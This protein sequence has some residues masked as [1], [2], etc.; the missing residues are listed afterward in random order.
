MSAH[1]ASRQQLGGDAV[2]LAV[3]VG[4]DLPVLGVDP[5]AAGGEGGVFDQLDV[6]E[7][8][9]L[10]LQLREGVVERLPLRGMNGDA[11]VG[12]VTTSFIASA[13]LAVSTCGI[14][15]PLALGDATGDGDR[16]LDDFRQRRGFQL[17]CGS[18][19]SCQ[20]RRSGRPTAC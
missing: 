15:Q 19:R 13:R 17:A 7:A 5:A 11:D 16:Q 14:D 2:E 9:P 4:I 1:S 12:G 3:E 6:R 8:G 18:R 20:R 10:H